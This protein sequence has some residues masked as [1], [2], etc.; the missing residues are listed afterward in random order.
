MKVVPYALLVSSQIYAMLCIVGMVSR[1]WS[2][3]RLKDSTIVKH[4]LKYLRKTKN[5]MLVHHCDEIIS[6]RY[7]DLDFHS[8]K[9]SCKSTSS[10]IFTLGGGVVN[11]RCVK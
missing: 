4:I 8:N 1:Y 2:N 10:Y 6:I 7:T 3:S 5:Y 9:D 11:W